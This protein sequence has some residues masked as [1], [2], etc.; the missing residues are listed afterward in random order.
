MGNGPWAIKGKS[1]EPHMFEFTCIYLMGSAGFDLHS[2]GNIL[3][4]YSSIVQVP[5]CA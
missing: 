5:R 3:K 1:E 4:Y 2:L